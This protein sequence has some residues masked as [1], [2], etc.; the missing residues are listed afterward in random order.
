MLHL[1][2]I[3]QIVKFLLGYL[4]SGT[5]LPGFNHVPT[6]SKCSMTLGKSLNHARLP[7]PICKVRV[8]LV[9]GL[10]SCHMIN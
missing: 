6:T 9:C 1:V 2:L 3:R 4:G 5:N 8:G 10:L 7:I